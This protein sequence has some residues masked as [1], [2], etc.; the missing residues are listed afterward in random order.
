MT[1]HAT[2]LLVTW[3]SVGALAVYIVRGMIQCARK[4]RGMASD[5]IQ[6]DARNWSRTYMESLK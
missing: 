3:L 4:P 6:P 2:V 5:R 1:F